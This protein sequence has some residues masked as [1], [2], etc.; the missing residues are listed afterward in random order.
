VN[1][2]EREKPSFDQR[3][4]PWT[5]PSKEQESGSGALRPGS[6]SEEHREYEIKREGETA[7]SLGV[8]VW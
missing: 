3:P 2:A 1:G 5:R 7:T 6:W 8:G 4:R